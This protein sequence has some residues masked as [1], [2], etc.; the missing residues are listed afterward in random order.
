M[1]SPYISAEIQENIL[2]VSIKRP[3]K[4]NA[5]TFDMV[6]AL[7]EAVAEV[8]KFPGVRAV[9]V[10]GE[11]PVFCAGVD[12]ASLVQ[13]RAEAGEAN[14]ARWLRRAA[15]RLQ[16]ALHLIESTETPVIG[17]LHGQVIGLGLE[18][19]L[20]FD[21]RVCSPGCLFSIPEARM[22]LVA[23]VGGTT[24]LARTVGPSRAKDLLMTARTIGAEEALQW[25]L[26]NRVA[27]DDDVFGAAVTLAGHIAAN[28]PLA[29]GMAKRI[30]DQGDGL[31]KHSQMAIER[32]AQ[33]QLITTDDVTEAATSFFE[34]RA[35]DFKGR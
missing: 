4:R 10:R 3:E 7:G 13:M 25:G 9:I 23:D 1:D 33:S 20:S 29:V 22:G 26:V 12:I 17:A 32:W 15:D 18:V 21:L 2:V 35:P 19:A 8:D 5:M 34:K 24:R 28:A 11:G 16:Y 14:A 30:V 31:D 27:E 6:V